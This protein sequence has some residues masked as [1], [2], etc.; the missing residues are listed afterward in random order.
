MTRIAHVLSTAQHRGAERFAL[1]LASAM[2]AAGHAGPTLALT[3]GGAPPLLDTTVLGARR[4][5]PSTL[6]ALRRAVADSDVVIAH[7][8]SSLTACATALAGRQPF[9]YR[10]IG[11]PRFWLHSGARQFRTKL[12]LRRSA[13]VVVM[14]PEAA[15]IMRD[16]LGDA[17]RVELI[18]KGLETGAPP[19]SRDE[20]DRARAAL[21]L[22]PATRIV[23]YLG[24]LSSE[25]D[26][27]LAIDAVALLPA[28]HLMVIGGG[29]LEAHVADHAANRLPGRHSLIGAVADPRRALVAADVLLLP[30]RTE[31]VPSAPLEAALLGIPSV[32][33]DVGGA[34]TTVVDG[35]TGGV[36]RERDARRLARALE[37]VIDARDEMGPAAR[38]YVR[39]N[40]SIDRCAAAWV[41]LCTDL[42]RPPA[43]G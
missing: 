29:P 2:S 40:F 13:A 12:L 23:A 32:V 10:S 36:V 14:W 22:A 9:V 38:T 41:D 33:T 15:D 28:V 21:G 7:G 30:S 25:K 42:C 5:A 16:L 1:E 31:G 19:R 27:L 20:C 6:W 34:A 35:L 3:A 37:R 43:Q 17:V 18:R 8:A 24:A 4:Y 11:D 39:D 26:P